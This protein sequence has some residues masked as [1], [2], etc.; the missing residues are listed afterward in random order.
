MVYVIRAEARWLVAWQQAYCKITNMNLSGDWTTC[1]W[2]NLRDATIF[3]TR[4]AAE[5]AIKTAGN[6]W[7]EA[8]S[9]TILAI[10]PLNISCI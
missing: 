4:E 8:V 7:V 2:S 3:S 10:N 9:P 1:R 6:C 5:R